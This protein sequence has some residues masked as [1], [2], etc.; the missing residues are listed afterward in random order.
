M[1]GTYVCWVQD[2]SHKIIRCAISTSQV[3]SSAG[4]STDPPTHSWVARTSKVDS[5]SGS[6]WVDGVIGDVILVAAGSEES[7]DTSRMRYAPVAELGIPLI[8]EIGPAPLRGL[9]W[10][11]TPRCVLEL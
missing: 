9:V 2:T 7:E 5:W 4:R 1:Q 3:C 6:L 10:A 8:G 11:V